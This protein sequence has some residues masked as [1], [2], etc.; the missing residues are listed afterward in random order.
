MTP[1]K[2]REPRKPLDQS[3]LAFVRGD[4]IESEP[5][6]PAQPI[7]GSETAA[8]Q[9]AFTDLQERVTALEQMTPNDNT[10]ALQDLEAQ[11]TPLAE[12]LTAL[13][14]QLAPQLTEL[15]QRLAD[16]EQE[17]K[18]WN[19]I[20]QFEDQL[21]QLTQQVE[22]MGNS[23]TQHQPATAWQD[24]L[25]EL[26]QLLQERWERESKHF[27][28][29]EHQL[30]HLSQQVEQLGADFR[31]LQAEVRQRLD[32]TA[33]PHTLP[34]IAAPDPVTSRLDKVPD[35]SPQPLSDQPPSQVSAPKMERTPVAHRPD[36]DPFL[37]RLAN[38]LDEF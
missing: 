11:L 30:T 13:E 5:S 35:T 7:L 33:A 4:E 18:H 10:Q 28:Q 15:R 31:Q 17:S 37:N 38:L 9:Q 22:D 29:I 20:I 23:T 2:S 1:K 21:T 34:A 8:W 24:R 19:Q 27:I 32:E 14:Q 25:R 6:A 16:L 36:S 12:R 3:F 26:E